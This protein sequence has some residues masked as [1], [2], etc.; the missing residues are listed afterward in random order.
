MIG[1]RAGYGRLPHGALADTKGE[2]E[3]RLGVADITIA[4]PAGE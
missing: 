1:P 2:L 4:P 3:Y